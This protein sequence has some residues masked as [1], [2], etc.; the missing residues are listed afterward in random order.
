MFNRMLICFVG[1]FCPFYRAFV[2]VEE[3]TECYERIWYPTVLIKES[4]L[5]FVTTFSVDSTASCLESDRDL[6]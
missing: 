5:R 6:S 1:L 2:S 3:T 4:S